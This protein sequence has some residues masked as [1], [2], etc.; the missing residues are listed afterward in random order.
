MTANTVDLE[1]GYTSAE[2][3]ILNLVERAVRNCQKAESLSEY[4]GID[5][6][7]QSYFVEVSMALNAVE[8][9]INRNARDRRKVMK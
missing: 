4:G 2:V 6:E 7:L 1:F 3:K 8:G 9:H 5:C